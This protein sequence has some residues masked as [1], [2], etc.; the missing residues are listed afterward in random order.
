MNGKALPPPLIFN[1]EAQKPGLHALIIG[2]SV[3]DFLGK[4]ATKPTDPTMLTISNSLPQ[5]EGPAQAARDLADFLIAR[6]DR[7]TKPLSTLR[8]L[9]APSQAEAAAG[10]TAFQGVMAPTSD[11]IEAAIK[12]WQKDA[13][14]SNDEATLFFFSGHG[15]QVS[16]VDSIILPQDFLGGTTVFDKTTKVMDIWNGMAVSKTVPAIAQNQFYFIDACR[17]DQDLYRTLD[18]SD[19][20]KP[21]FIDPLGVDKRN[22]PIFFAAGPGQ[23]T[24]VQPGTKPSTRFGARLLSC[25]SDGGGG[26]KQNGQWVVTVNALQT[27]LNLLSDYENLGFTE[28]VDSFEFDK[29]TNGRQVIL[30]LD[31]TPSVPC[32]LRFEASDGARKGHSI[33]MQPPL[34]DKK[35]IPPELADP[36]KT[37]IPAGYYTFSADPAGLFQT[38]GVD[39]RPP[40]IDIRFGSAGIEDLTL[41]QRNL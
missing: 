4:V 15:T 14:R 19:V 26:I 37:D 18:T 22:A 28:R 9:A 33:V 2:V 25:L 12:D 30:S 27:A 3:Y 34:S 17:D 32:T 1:D 21:L 5:L 29:S 7:L 8:F 11:N 40:L 16:K 6:K 38:D 20:R 24:K 39:I 23:Q 35:T 41:D 31:K 36:H 13:A 10:S